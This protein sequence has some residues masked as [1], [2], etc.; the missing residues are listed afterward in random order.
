M[1][2][3]NKTMFTDIMGQTPMLIYSNLFFFKKQNPEIHKEL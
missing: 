3:K 1:T 2:N